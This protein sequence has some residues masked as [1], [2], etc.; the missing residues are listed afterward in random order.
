MNTNESIHT[1]KLVP[2]EGNK[3]YALFFIALSYN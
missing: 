2:Y 3:L 1:K